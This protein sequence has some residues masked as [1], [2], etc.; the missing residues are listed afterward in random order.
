[1]AIRPASWLFRD[2]ARLFE[3]AAGVGFFA[4]RRPT[5]LSYLGVRPDIQNQTRSAPVATPSAR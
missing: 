4:G 1:M 2:V 3:R 5:S